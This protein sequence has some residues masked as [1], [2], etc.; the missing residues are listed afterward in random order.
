M[1]ATI[2]RQ[3]ER[4]RAEMRALTGAGATVVDPVALFTANS[5]EPDPWQRTVLRSAARRVLLC[6]CRQA[7]KST[8]AAAL[9]VHQAVCHPESLVLMVSPSLR[10][11]Q[12]LFR[13]SLETYRA[14]KRP[15]PADA[16]N[17]LSL[18]L[19]N[20][21]RIVS[22]PG[23]EAT[24]RGYSGVSLLLI[25]EASRVPDE[26]MVG[27]R[28]MLAVSNGR[29]VALSTPWG[30]QGW[31]F[32]AWS[33]GE[34]WERYQVTAHEVP[35]IRPEFLEEERRALGELA[36]KAEY[37]T[38]FVD[39]ES[40]VFSSASIHAALDDRLQPLFGSAA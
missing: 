37:L 39:I 33:E 30:R 9:A 8:V 22:L 34:G 31:F 2:T 24:I 10:Q 27:V 7:G 14:A 17:R 20:G 29:L 35:R 25:D 28:P 19:S 16:E 1:N 38:E 15:V 13:K 32:D 40:Q 4:T 23:R 6:C 26:M 11:S 3:L 12:E 36:F 5:G 21:S 18:E